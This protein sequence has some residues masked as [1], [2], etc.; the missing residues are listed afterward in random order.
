MIG[1]M[2]TP[3]LHT[4]SSGP[5]F[6][7]SLRIRF[8]HCDP[9]GIVYF[10]QYFVMLNGIV[11]DWVSDGLGIPYAELLGPRR[12]GLPTVRIDTEFRAISRMGDEV[13]LGLRVEHLGR[14]SLT[15]TL[16]CSAGD[17]LRV[18]ARTVIVAT[19]LDTHRPVAIPDDLRAAIE[20]FAAASS[21]AV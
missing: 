12:I 21:A 14:S 3:P 1:R 18:L 10:P 17:E 11:E 19:S 4:V 13:S 20:R 5:R 9:A 7:R 16:D 6:A 2:S 8:G 15:L